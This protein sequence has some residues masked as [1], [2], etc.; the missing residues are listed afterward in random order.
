MRLEVQDR[1]RRMPVTDLHPADPRLSP[2]TTGRGLALLAS[3]VDRW[4][5]D[6]SETGK[7]V[8]AEVG[9]GRPNAVPGAEPSQPA[10]SPSGPDVAG[11]VPA[12]RAAAAAERRQVRLLGVPVRML[13]ESA[14][15]FADLQ[16]EMQVIGL[17][18]NGPAELIALAATSREISARIGSL[19]R[20]GSDAAE[21]ALARGESVVDFDVL[22]ADDAVATFDRL[23]TLI[24]RVGDEVVRR[25]L[26]TMPPSV[27]LTAYRQWYRDEI[28]AQLTG[29]APS[30]CPFAAFPP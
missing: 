5:V 26:L 17:D 3:T 22:V 8:W 20:A 25:H 23:A 10:V 14:R 28:V 21:A 19:P 6:P 7:V 13:V 2:S 15:Q 4:G 29:R 16:R 9:T 27:E 24:R 1:S 30:R 12:Y 11:V 18:H